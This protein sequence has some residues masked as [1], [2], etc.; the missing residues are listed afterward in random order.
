[1]IPGSSIKEQIEKTNQENYVV[2]EI[3]QQSK[4]NYRQKFNMSVDI[5]IPADFSLHAGDL[6]YCDFLNQLQLKH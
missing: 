1:M 4:Q 6:V 2:E 5:I 3:L